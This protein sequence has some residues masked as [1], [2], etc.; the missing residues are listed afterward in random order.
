MIGNAGL[1]SAVLAEIEIALDHHELI[2][3]RIRAE[4][5]VREQISHQICLDTHCEL[6]QRIG[7]ISTVYRHNPN[8][9]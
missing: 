1:T 4:K 5:E 3:I 2:K 7:Q 9:P 6:I 8:K